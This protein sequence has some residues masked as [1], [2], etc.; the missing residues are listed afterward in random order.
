MFK[1]GRAGSCRH[2]DRLII[3]D[4]T[5]RPASKGQH[6]FRHVLNSSINHNIVNF[7]IMLEKDGFI[8]DSSKTYLVGNATPAVRRLAMEHTGILDNYRS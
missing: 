5:A 2:V 3:I 7:D 6:G 8:T 4:F 1:V